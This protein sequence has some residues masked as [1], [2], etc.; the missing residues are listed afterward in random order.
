MYSP[1]FPLRFHQYA[2]LLTSED[3][4]G[5]PSLVKEPTAKVVSGLEPHRRHSMLESAHDVGGI[6]VF[7]YLFAKVR[8][9]CIFLLTGNLVVTKKAFTLMAVEKTPLLRSP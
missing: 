4:H 5:R 8:K 1:A 9:R 3:R 7:I 2:Q 6:S